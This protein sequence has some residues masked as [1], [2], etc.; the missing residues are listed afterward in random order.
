MNEQVY[1][2]VE[3]LHKNFGG[4]A[5]V[6]DFTFEIEKGA[7]HG[8]IGPNGAGKTTIFNVISGFYKPSAG[9]ILFEGEN[10]AGRAE[11]SLLM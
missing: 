5:A 8:L 11:A 3:G 1:F 2:K 9:K 7:I 4:L 6:D 10:I